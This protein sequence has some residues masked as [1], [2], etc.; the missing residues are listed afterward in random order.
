MPSSVLTRNVSSSI[1]IVNAGA[2]LAL[3]AKS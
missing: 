1:A 3:T 2:P